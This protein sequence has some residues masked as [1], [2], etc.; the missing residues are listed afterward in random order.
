M[1]MFPYFEDCFSVRG[2][3]YVMAAGIMSNPI[4]K[5][6]GVNFPVFPLQGNVTT[7]ETS[8]PLEYNV[9]SPKHGALVCPLKPNLVRISGGVHAVGYKNR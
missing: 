6:I 8:E 7:V 5:T 9:Y 2:E 4:G 1:K 3:L